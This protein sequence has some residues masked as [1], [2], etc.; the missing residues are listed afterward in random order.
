MQQIGKILIILGFIYTFI[1]SY[2]NNE[3]TCVNFRENLN[4][5]DVIFTEMA[6]SS[7]KP[8]VTSLSDH[9]KKVN[10]ISN[11]PD[12]ASPETSS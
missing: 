1:R 7:M 12:G 3:P 5:I 8:H 10:S 6:P 4:C 9:H 2:K 11:I